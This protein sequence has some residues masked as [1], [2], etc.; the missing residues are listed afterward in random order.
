MISTFLFL[1]AGILN[2]V[3]DVCKDKYFSSVFNRGWLRRFEKFIDEMYAW[4][5]KYHDPYGC[6]GFRRKKWLWGLI[7]KPV[8][9]TSLWHLSKSLMLWCISIAISLILIDNE[10]VLP[11]FI[12]NMFLDYNFWTYS[13]LYA[14]WFRAWFGLGFYTFYNYILINK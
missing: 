3:M 8:F 10:K 2:S 13:I 11:F 6:E 4:R 5:N 12:L 9:T 7:N 14:I 1:L